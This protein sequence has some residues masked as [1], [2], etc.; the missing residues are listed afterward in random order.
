MPLLVMPDCLQCDDFL[1]VVFV[2]VCMFVFR[3][4]FADGL[5]VTF[6]VLK[7]VL[8]LLGLNLLVPSCLLVVRA[9]GLSSMGKKIRISIT[10]DEDIHR[11]VQEIGF[12]I[13]KLCENAMKDAV[14][15]MTG[16]N[17]SKDPGISREPHTNNHKNQLVRGVGLEPTKAFATGASVL[18]LRPNSDIPARRGFAPFETPY[19][20]PL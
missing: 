15:R 7:F 5:A 6:R 14:R 4:G 11:D 19:P 20:R 9:R 18:L 1:P 3:H 13:S 10:V 2:R 12:N 16:S 17:S 8:G